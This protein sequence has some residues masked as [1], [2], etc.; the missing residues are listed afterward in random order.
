LNKLNSAVKANGG[1]SVAQAFCEI[2]L[3]KPTI[4]KGQLDWSADMN[5]RD[6]WVFPVDMRFRLTGMG[7]MPDMIRPLGERGEVPDWAFLENNYSDRGYIGAKMAIRP[8]N[9]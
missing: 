6:P 5:I 2:I 1:V 7:P 9:S 4:A 3:K 8:N